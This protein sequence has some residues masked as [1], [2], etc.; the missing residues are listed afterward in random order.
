M[1]ISGQNTAFVIAAEIDSVNPDNRT[2]A[3]SVKPFADNDPIS[4]F[5]AFQTKKNGDLVRQSIAIFIKPQAD[6]SQT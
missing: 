6:F 5:S 4:D 2:F 3:P 1:A